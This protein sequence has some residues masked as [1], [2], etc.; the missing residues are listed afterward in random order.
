MWLPG[1]KTPGVMQKLKMG[2]LE[3]GLVNWHGQD[4]GS[5]WVMTSS[6]HRKKSDIGG[7]VMVVM[8]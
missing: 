7:I 8:M 1:R 2:A 3:N 5:T 4:S 6:P